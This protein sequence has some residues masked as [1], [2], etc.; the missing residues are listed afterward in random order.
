MKNTL[1]SVLVLLKAQ[2]DNKAKENILYDYVN[3]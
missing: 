3:R 2:K 1:S